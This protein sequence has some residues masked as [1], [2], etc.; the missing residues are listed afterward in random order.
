VI[1]RI[2]PLSFASF[3]TSN[4]AEISSAADS[5]SRYCIV[6]LF[7]HIV[8]SCLTARAQAQLPADR[9]V[10]WQVPSD[11]AAARSDLSRMR[12]LG[13]T[14]VRTGLIEDER[15]LRLSEAFEISLFQEVAPAYLTSRQ[16]ADTLE[17]VRSQLIRAL[18]AAHIDLRTPARSASLD[19]RIRARDPR[20]SRYACS[21][22]RRDGQLLRGRDSITCLCSSSRID[23]RD[24]VDFVLLNARDKERPSS[25][26]RRWSAAHDT[27]AG[28]LPSVPGML[29]VRRAGCKARGPSS[30]RPGFSR[31]ALTDVIENAP[32]AAAVFAYRWR[33]TDELLP[34]FHRADRDPYR[35]TYGLRDDDGSFRPAANVLAGF[36]RGEQEAFAFERGEVSYRDWPWTVILTWVVILMIAIL[37]AV[38]PRFRNTVPRYFLAHGFY[39]DSVREGRNLLLVSSLT[40]L[41]ALAIS[42]GIALASVVDLLGMRR[43]SES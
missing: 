34:A 32:N 35:A 40:M 20:A 23:V 6:L 1:R 38:S 10:V 29:R 12:D 3:R 18:S 8:L 7:V 41:L 42:S 17:A 13:V 19:I 4:S 11:P 9:G 33:D 14:A 27:P 22:M 26:L 5:V 25:L 28:W 36:Y 21:S 24:L 37:Y 31:S 2:P 39:R 16:L 15:I 30:L 43:R